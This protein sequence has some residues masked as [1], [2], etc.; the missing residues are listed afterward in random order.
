[1]DSRL[2][3]LPK[4]SEWPPVQIVNQLIYFGE[5]TGGGEVRGADLSLKVSF[6]KT[7]IP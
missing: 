4:L 7:S 5:N 3:K 1:M 6:Y 2:R